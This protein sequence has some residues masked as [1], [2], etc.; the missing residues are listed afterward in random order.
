MLID[1]FTVIAQ[2]ANFLVLVWLLKRFLY[3]PVLGALDAREKR[4]AAELADADAKKAEARAEREEFRRKN[5]EFDQQRAALLNK[6]MGEA[7]TE[8][9]RLLEEARK[10]ADGLRARLQDKVNSE[11]RVL[12]EEISRRAQAEVFAIARKALTDLAGAS[13]EERMVD[14]FVARLREWDK[15]EKERLASALNPSSGPA[16]VRSAFEFSPSQR[17]LIEGTVKEALSAG[18][19]VRFEVSP[20][21]VGGIELNLHGQKIAWSLADYLASLERGVNELLKAQARP[22]ANRETPSPLQGE[23]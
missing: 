4:I 10:D 18:I 13:L 6:A 5:E 8:H 17:G 1:W 21:V 12:G 16:F 20:D 14:V 22:E 2:A 23:G 7:A 15:D 19:E 3:K 9:R 11:Y